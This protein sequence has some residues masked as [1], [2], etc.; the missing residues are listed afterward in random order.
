MSTG[1]NVIAP[2]LSDRSLK[3][4]VSL[5]GKV[6]VVTGGGRGLGAAIVRRLSQAG[7]AVVVADLDAASAE[8]LAADL[9]GAGARAIAATVDVSDPASIAALAETAVAELGS[10]DVWVNNAGIY[11][12]VDFLE[13]TPEQLDAML[14]VNVRGTF[15]G[16]QAAARAMVAA[17]RPGVIVNLGSTASFD[18]A[19]NPAHYVASKHAVVGLTKRLA[20]ELG[21]HGIRAL[22]VAPTLTRTPGTDLKREDPAAAAGMDAYA[23]DLPLG[24]MGVPD[25]IAR[26]VLFA[27]TGL[28][29][30][31]TGSAIVV[32]GGALAG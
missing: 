16:A 6:A 27:A 12:V 28:S 1:T 26:A 13:T 21:P 8:G 5:D 9:N 29:E 7:A 3:E 14:A 18:A 30:Y 11:P 20:I 10:L 17:G 23:S 24:R 15:F 32:D 19:D 31:L 2:D 22:A 4:L 25:D